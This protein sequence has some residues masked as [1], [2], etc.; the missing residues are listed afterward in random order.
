[1]IVRSI[2]GTK[3]RLLSLMSSMISYDPISSSL[4]DLFLFTNL[5]VCLSCKVVPSRTNFATTVNEKMNMVHKG[6]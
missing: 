5:S 2:A 6:M 3:Y 4:S 1:M